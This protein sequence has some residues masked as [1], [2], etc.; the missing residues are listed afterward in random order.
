MML[1]SANHVAATPSANGN[2]GEAA[3]FPWRWF[4]I[5]LG[6][7]FLRAL[8]NL[9]YPMGRDQATASV[10]AQRILEGLSLYRDLWDNRPPGNFLFY[11]P[12]VK[13]L[14]PVMWVS[15]V[16][17]ILVV[18]ALA[19][20]L[21]RFACRH[22]GRPTAAL[23]T[24]AAV[25]F[26][27]SAGYTHAAQPDALLV[28]FV[29][30]AL[31]LLTPN[32]PSSPLRAIGAGVMLAAAFWVKYNSLAFVPFV[33]IA[34]V[35]DGSALDSAH[36]RLAL[37]ISWNDFIRR[38]I[39]LGAGFAAL[40]FAGLGWFWANG[41]WPAFREVEIDVLLRYGSSGPGH[42]SSA[43]WALGELTRH[44]GMWNH[45][46]VVVAML[47]AWKRLEL[48]RLAPVLLAYFAGLAA[49]LLPGRVHN[50]YI[51]IIFP[52]LGLIW[53]YVIVEILRGFRLIEQYLSWRN[54]RFARLA[55]WIAMA[56]IAFAL[57]LTDA[58]SLVRDAR[59][60]A[61]WVRDPRG[62]Y[63][64]YFPENGLDKF[65]DQLKV[66]DFVRAHSAAED[67]VYVWGTQP[68]INFLGERRSPGRFIS[69]LPLV[70]SWGPERWRGELMRD[71]NSAPPLFIVVA[72]H[73][74]V[75][76]ITD[77]L[78]DSEQYLE[79]YTA[80]REFI[81]SRY[82]RALNLRGFD[83]YRRK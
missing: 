1:D 62:S 17:D 59:S 13:L 39:L 33:A 41:T 46:I 7:A 14:G 5:T 16:I 47:V 81:S 78:R 51:E 80:L 20:L 28:V 49:I 58:L 70:A 52:F 37:R 43:F 42:Q 15:A 9:R 10:I 29:L 68:L 73:D 26:H 38:M 69:N 18:L 45:A 79:T 24:L 32:V 77:E 66:I 35:L 63:S 19:G 23:G 48:G 25:S 72:R 76:G 75:P 65:G 12:F 53:G 22:V 50:Y 11:T 60:M 82:E 74:A 21:F 6:L 8:P 3:A 4:A 30:G 44:M 71:L 36:P 57:L 40:V 31:A 83:I 64:N 34:P 56:N 54:F 55:L 67:A 27:C 61:T 2:A